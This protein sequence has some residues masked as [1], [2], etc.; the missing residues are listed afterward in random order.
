MP[1]LRPLPLVSAVAVFALSFFLM[2]A[3]GSCGA[4]RD[5]SVGYILGAENL[6]HGRIV[7][8]DPVY[9]TAAEVLGENGV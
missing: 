6:A 2:Q 4:T 8:D 7:Y 9:R 1:T 5:D 3:H